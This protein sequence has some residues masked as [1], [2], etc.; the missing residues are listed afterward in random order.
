MLS[1]GMKTHCLERQS[2]T[3]R[4]VV[5]VEEAGSCSMKSMEMEFHGFEGMESCFRSLYGLCLGTFACAQVVHE[6]MYSLMKVCTSS[7]VNLQHM[8]SKV[9]FCPKCPEG[10]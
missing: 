5:C 7:Q 4:I 10:R 9:W 3:T 2:M 6:E 1:V 8:S